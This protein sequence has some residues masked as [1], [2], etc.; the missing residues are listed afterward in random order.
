MNNE[1]YEYLKEI[2]NDG[3]RLN[4]PREAR[5]ILLGRIINALERSELTSVEAEELEKMLELGSRNEYREALSFSILG[6]LEGSIP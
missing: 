4:M 5:F 1:E 2:I 6:N 3:L